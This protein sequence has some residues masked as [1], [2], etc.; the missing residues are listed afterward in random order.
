V[1]A[2]AG[3]VFEAV[4]RVSIFGRGFAFGFGFFIASTG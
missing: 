3:A 4:I 2:T 1:A